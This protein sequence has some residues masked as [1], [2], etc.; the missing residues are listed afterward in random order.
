M[1]SGQ[2][3]ID[4]CA[5]SYMTPYI[6]TLCKRYASSTSNENRTNGIAKAIEILIPRIF[7]S[8]R[9]LQKATDGALFPI[10]T[11]ATFCALGLPVGV[12]N[13]DSNDVATRMFNGLFTVGCSGLGGFFMGSACMM[14]PKTS[15]TI[16]ASSG[17]YFYARRVQNM[18]EQNQSVSRE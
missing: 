8:Y 10:T 2:K 7:A 9:E 16:A 17:L 11:A 6:N 4:R 18:T 12:N 5:R 3:G 15:F 1:F 14:F 13:P